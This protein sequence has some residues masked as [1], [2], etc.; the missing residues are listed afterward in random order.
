MSDIPPHHTS[1][2]EQLQRIYEVTGCKTQSGLAAL[3]GIRQSS[4][5]LAAKQE[6][7]PNS[8]FIHLFRVGIHPDSI[9]TGTGRRF[10]PN[11]SELE[12]AVPEKHTIPD[13][14]VIRSLLK[15]FSVDDLQSELKRRKRK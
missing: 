9:F 3:L 12:E 13:R 10:L 15:C 11:L 2:N 1:G 5:S 8:W 14:S 4:V 7:V 6:T